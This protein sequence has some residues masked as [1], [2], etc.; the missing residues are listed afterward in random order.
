[1]ARSECASMEKQEQSKLKR[2]GVLRIS[3]GSK[4]EAFDFPSMHTLIFLSM[5]RILCL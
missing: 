3:G 2:D 5:T 4:V 1:M